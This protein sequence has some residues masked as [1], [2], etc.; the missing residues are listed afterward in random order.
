MIADEPA[1]LP[2]QALGWMCVWASWLQLGVQAKCP[3]A[4]FLLL[5]LLMVLQVAA[6]LLLLLL[7]VLVLV[8]LPVMMMM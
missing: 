8:L 2:V 6:V 5:Q 3:L 4:P 7:L 1:L